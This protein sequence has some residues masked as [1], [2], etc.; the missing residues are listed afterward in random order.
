MAVV[1]GVGDH[2]CEYMTRGTVVVIGPQ[3]RNFAAGMSGGVAFVLDEDGTFASRCNRGM[4]ELFPLEEEDDV[5]TVRLLI[6]RHLQYT[7]S[8]V[9]ERLL[10]DW[11]TAR[12]MFVKVYPTEYRK[13][14]E[15][16]H[17]DSEAIRL[18]SV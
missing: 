7:G 8:S 13:V 5:S 1:E 3:G 12:G 15:K 14:L 4:V 17:L 16:M 2:G 6:Q 11:E 10:A 18:A 9:A